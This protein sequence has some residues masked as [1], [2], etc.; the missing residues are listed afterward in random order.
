MR[1]EITLSCPGFDGTLQVL[2]ERVRR[3][4]INILDV[5][6]APLARQVAHALLDPEVY[7][8][9][10]CTAMAGLM[11]VKSRALLPWQDPLDEPELEEDELEAEPEEEPTQVRERLLAL[12]EVFREAAE[13]LKLRSDAMQE[14]LRAAQTRAMGAPSFLDEVTFVDEVTAFDLLLVMNQVLRRASEDRTYH[15]KVNDTYLLNQRISEVFDFLIQRRGRNTAFTEI[16]SRATPRTEAVLTFL[17]IIYLVNQGR[18]HAWQ[19]APYS[20]IIMTVK[21]KS[22]TGAAPS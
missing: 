11:F 14:R 17:A 6:L 13:Q 2:I 3:F 10:P 22:E 16:V 5:R 9:T 20:D 8:F 7:D 1:Y 18:I 21:E 19:K 12:Y 15:V 4:E